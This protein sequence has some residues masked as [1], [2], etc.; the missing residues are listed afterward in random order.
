M[1]SLIFCFLLVCSLPV[2][3]AQGNFIELESKATRK[4]KAEKLVYIVNISQT[5]EYDYDDY[6]YTVDEPAQE[7]YPIPNK[8][9]PEKKRKKEEEAEETYTPPAYEPTPTPEYEEENSLK[10]KQ[11]MIRQLSEALGIEAGELKEMNG[12]FMAKQFGREGDFSLSF[13]IPVSRRTEVEEILNQAVDTWQLVKGEISSDLQLT[14]EKELLSEAIAQARNKAQAVA[15]SEKRAL[16]SILSI[17][18]SSPNND[19]LN[20]LYGEQMMSMIQSMFVAG[21]NSEWVEVK[22]AVKVRFAF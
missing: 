5:E 7:E 1:K 3:R 10:K 20:Q 13:Q 16:G 15:Q 6:D 18:E 9:K 19:I 12:F 21:T 11:E 22:Q 8:R 17:Q 2:L 14:I 4:V